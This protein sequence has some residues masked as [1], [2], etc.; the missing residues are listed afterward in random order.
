MLYVNTYEGSVKS[1]AKQLLT[2]RLFI[3]PHETC[4]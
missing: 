1:N 4:Q 2:A 3:K